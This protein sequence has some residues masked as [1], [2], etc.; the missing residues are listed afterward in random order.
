MSNPFASCG[1][2]KVHSICELRRYN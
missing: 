1:A 2:R